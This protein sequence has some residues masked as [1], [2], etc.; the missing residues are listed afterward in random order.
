MDLKGITWMGHVYQKFEDMCLEVEEV[1]YQDTVKYVENQVQTVGAS[2]KKLYSE[3]MQDMMRDFPPSGTMDN[4]KGESTFYLPIKKEAGDF[5]K[6]RELRKPHTGLNKSNFKVDCDQ[7]TKYTEVIADMTEDANHELSPP[8]FNDIDNSFDSTA[9]KFVKGYH[10][11]SVKRRNRSMHNKFNQEC[12]PVFGVAPNTTYMKKDLH[13]RS[14]S[15]EKTN[16][17]HSPSHHQMPTPSSPNS[18]EADASASV[19]SCP[20]IVHDCESISGPSNHNSDSVDSIGRSE[21]EI[22]CFSDADIS[23]ESTGASD[24]WTTDAIDCITVP[25]HGKGSVQQLKTIGV[26]DSCVLVTGNELLSGSLDRKRKPY[27]KIKIRDAISLRSKSSRKREYELAT[28]YGG[29]AASDLNSK[30]TLMPT[31]SKKDEVIAPKNDIS[32]LESEW[33]LL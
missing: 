33:E 15:C 32:E 11:S 23:E 7:L 26:E 1:I 13:G 22:R 24:C 20:Q 4:V 18:V 21:M 2:V 12:L 5:R 25:E 28:L 10:L 9:G 31:L 19:E 27:Y 16:A 29:I 14:P 17:N 3:V 6:P 30:G 8:G